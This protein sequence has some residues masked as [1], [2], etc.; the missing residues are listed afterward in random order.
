MELN[1]IGR[2]RFVQSPCLVVRRFTKNHPSD[3]GCGMCWKRNIRSRYHH[4]RKKVGAPMFIKIDQDGIGE[5]GSSDKTPESMHGRRKRRRDVARERQNVPAV[6]PKRLSKIIAEMWAPK[7]PASSFG[8][9]LLL[10][11]PLTLAVPPARALDPNALPTNGSIVAGAGSIAQS[12]NSM[13]VTQ[14]S[15]RM[16]ANWNTFNIG[17]SAKVT[18]AQPSAQAV[19]LN[20]GLGADPSQILGQL[21][22]NGQVFLINP[23]GVIFGRGARVDVGGIVASALS[24]GNDDF[25]AGRYRFFNS[26]G[27]GSVVNQGSIHAAPEGYVALLGKVVRNDGTIS[28]PQGTVAL[29]AGE[30][31]TL[32]IS[33]SG[34]LGVSVDAAAL[35]AL[36]ENSGAIQ[37]EGGLVLMR[38]ASASALP[39]MVLKAGGSVEARSI[40]ERE[41]RVFLNGGANGETYVTGTIDTSAIAPGVKGGTV[42]VLGQKVGLMSGSIIDASGEAGGGTVLVGGNWQGKGPEHNATAVYM[43]PQAT[44]RADATGRGEGGTVVLWSQDYTGFYGNISAR[45]GALGG[46]A[47]MVVTSGHHTPWTPGRGEGPP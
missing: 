21:S 15:D 33:G 23:N 41:G 11:L 30:R 9:V 17:S 44:I 38:V 40:V 36:A 12:A 1:L 5:F 14:G 4:I 16:V 39:G 28:A 10:A 37:A 6:E 7:V 20:R 8:R 13:R 45:G 24:L 42:T 22:A 47:R 18:F 19:A 29:A 31:M 2:C 32:D 34:L 46:N 35:G 27:A 43:D 26:G 3:D 25:M